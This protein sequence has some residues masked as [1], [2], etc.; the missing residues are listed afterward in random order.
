MSRVR[1]G[2]A[3]L[4]ASS[5]SP[6]VSGGS[7]RRPGTRP[8]ATGD[9][10]AAALA[11]YVKP[12]DQDEYYL[13]Y[14]GGHSGQVFVAGVPSMRH[15][16]TI[17]VF[18]PYPGTGYGFDEESQGAC[19][20]A[21]PGATC[22]TPPCSKTAGDY[23]GRWLFVNDNANNRIARIDLRDLKTKPDPRADPQHDGQPRLVDG[24]R[25]HR[26]RARRHP[27]LGADR[28]PSTRRSRTTPRSTRARSRASR[29]TRRPAR[30]RIGWQIMTPPFN[31]DLGRDR[32][33]SVG[34]L[35]VL[36][37]V[38]H[39][40]APPASSRRRPPRRTGTTSRW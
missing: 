8:M 16:A 22:T 19:S 36:D 37:L 29:S 7:R 6:P 26:V 32:Q 17:P 4:H 25:Q 2:V 31:W 20:A 40:S 35:G 28:E 12:G 33:G 23:D 24:H 21:S 10:Q 11:S 38:Q 39:A 27:L 15:I 5:R 34:G 9:V 18:A 30:C 3:G 13:F 1:C 14:S